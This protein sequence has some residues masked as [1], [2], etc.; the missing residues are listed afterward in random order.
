M[1]K[2]FVEHLAQWVDQNG[3]DQVVVHAALQ[4]VLQIGRHCTGC[5]RNDLDMLTERELGFM[6][7]QG[8]RELEPTH[9]A[10]LTIGQN[11]CARVVL[12]PGQRLR[13]L[14]KDLYMIEAKMCKLMLQQP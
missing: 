6:S 7:P 12:D 5:D 3:F 11:Q 2:P 8:S 14:I 4:A 13:G 1:A 10:H 9:G